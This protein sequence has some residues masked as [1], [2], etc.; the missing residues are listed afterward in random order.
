MQDDSTKT[1]YKI[2]ALFLGVILIITALGSVLWI[3]QQD[4]QTSPR[5]LYADIY[6]NGD[7]KQSIL[8]SSVTEDYTFTIYNEQGNCNEIEVRPGSIGIISAD[9]PDK[10]CVHQ[11]FIQSSLLPITCLPNRL[12]IQ[13]RQEQN[14]VNENVDNLELSPDI[15]TY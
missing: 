15:V 13:I 5:K 7:L 9:C 4:A 3:I 2:Y 11:G 14:Q 6:Q 1:N 10:L 8:L 12:V